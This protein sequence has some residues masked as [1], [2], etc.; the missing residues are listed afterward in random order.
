M[1]QSEWMSFESDAWT[2][3]EKYAKP[4]LRIDEARSLLTDAKR[5]HLTLT[6]MKPLR[7]IYT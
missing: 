5:A 6:G 2:C 4:R 3:V 1:T 7:Y